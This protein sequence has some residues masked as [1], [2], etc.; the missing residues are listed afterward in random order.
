MN[1]LRTLIAAVAV[2][3]CSNIYAQ[4]DAFYSE[5]KSFISDYDKLAQDFLSDKKMSLDDY[6]L[7]YY[8][9]TFT[10]NYKPDYNG[11]A[12]DSLINLKQYEK[13]YQQLQEDHRTNPTSLQTLF[14]LMNIASY[15][16][17]EKESSVYQSRYINLVK[18]IMQ[19]GGDGLSPDNAI[20]VNSVMDEF[21]IL[22]TYFK[23]VAIGSKEFSDDYI[24]KITIKDSDGNTKD[25]FFDF[26]RYME[27]S[28]K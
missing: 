22:S 16:E 28:G 18:A 4:T 12:A 23:A 27:V 21:Q 15:L 26:K 9:F 20:R 13:A 25:V 17:K 14:D 6:T 7:L 19:A 24:D 8:G 1:K 2:L 11:G 3:A 5:I 10:D